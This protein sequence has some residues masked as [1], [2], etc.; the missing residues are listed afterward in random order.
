MLRFPRAK[1]RHWPQFHRQK[2]L[3]AALEKAVTCNTDAIGTFGGGGFDGG[4]YDPRPRLEP[5]GVKIVDESRQDESGT[6][7]YRF[8]SSIKVFGF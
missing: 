5:M 1:Q 2:T 6:I 8:S 7:T 3:G 4:P